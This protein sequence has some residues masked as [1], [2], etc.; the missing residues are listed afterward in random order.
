MSTE[1]TRQS[2]PSA[3]HCSTL[4]WA[5]RDTQLMVM[6]AHRYCLGRQSYIVGAAIDWLR[7][8]RKNF[9]RNTIRVIVRDTVEALQDGH[10]GS[11]LIDVPGWERLAS[12]L[13][14][15]MPEED[16]EWVKSSVAHRDRE[17]PLSVR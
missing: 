4:F 15:E 9:E 2:A 13:F 11:Q 10:A 17:W 8:H 14:L 3:S 1:E 16:Q 5:E 12:E 7:K 6:A